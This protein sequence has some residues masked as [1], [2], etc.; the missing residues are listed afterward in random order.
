MNTELN[1]FKREIREET[2]SGDVKKLKA[3]DK[4]VFKK[5]SNE[6]NFKSFEAVDGSL[7]DALASLEK[8]KLEKVQELLEEGKRLISVRMKEISLADKHG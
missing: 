6:M 3:S 7:D 4:L 8:R 1:A 5:K 2:L